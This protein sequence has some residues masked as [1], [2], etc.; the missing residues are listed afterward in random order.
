[1][2]ISTS[3]S[4]GALV[5]PAAAFDAAD[6]DKYKLANNIE[7]ARSIRGTR[8]Q[9]LSRPVR[10]EQFSSLRLRHE[11]RY[12]AYSNVPGYGMMWR[13][14]HRRRMDPFTNGAGRSYPDTAICSP[15][16]IL[17]MGRT[18]TA[19]GC[20][21]PPWMDV[22]ARWMEPYW[23]SR[24]IAVLFVQFPPARC[25]VAELGNRQYG[26]RRPNWAGTVVT[27]R[28]SSNALRQVYSAR[29][30]RNLSHMNHQVAKSGF[31]EVRPALSTQR[32]HLALRR[33]HQ[34]VPARARQEDVC[35]STGHDV[36]TRE[37]Q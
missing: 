23:P 1:M 2:A 14:F 12:G 6:N 9:F 25:P 7:E 10:Q 33:G 16:R 35:A 21:C 8:N 19:T 26:H 31:V 5:V 11:R 15:H 3:T 24:V 27:R 13:P 30:V 17:G 4:A 29:C 37:P 22:A 18:A 28:E 20:L 32:P 36:G 34:P